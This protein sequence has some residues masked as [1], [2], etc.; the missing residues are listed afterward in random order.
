MMAPASTWLTAARRLRNDVSVSPVTGETGS[1][2]GDGS[3]GCRAVVSVVYPLILAVWQS[4]H[5]CGWMPCR[6]SAR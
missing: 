1:G 5:G 2:S 3:G 6:S 4:G